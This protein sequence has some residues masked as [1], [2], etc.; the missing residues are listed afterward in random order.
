[1][2]MEELFEAI[3]GQ[4]NEEKLGAEVAKLTPE[5]ESAWSL[6]D[7][8]IN[9]FIER[10]KSMDFEHQELELQKKKWWFSV[11]K[12]HNLQGKK[13]RISEGKLYERVKK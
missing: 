10:A 8:K 1:M 9:G 2:D 11:E 7:A 4:H 12:A 6:I 5:E 13:L 3:T